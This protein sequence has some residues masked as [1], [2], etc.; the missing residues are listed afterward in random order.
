[1]NNG[2]ILVA[3]DRSSTSRHALQWAVTEGDRLEA[4]VEP[5]YVEGE[6]DVEALLPLSR[7]AALLVLGRLPEADV[8]GSSPMSRCLRQASCPVAVVP[9]VPVPEQTGAVTGGPQGWLDGLAE[10]PVR[11]VMSTDVLGADSATDVDTAWRMMLGAGFAHLPVM[12]QGRCVGVVHEADLLWRMYGWSQR[13]RAPLVADV[14]RKPAPTVAKD[15]TVREAAEALRGSVGDAVVVTDEEE[16]VGMLTA[17]DLHAALLRQPVPSEGPLVVGV[18][19]SAGS[20]YAL[21]WG[22][23]YAGQTGRGVLASSVSLLAPRPAFRT[24]PAPRE[25]LAS[26]AGAHKE[27]L[28]TALGQA[29]PSET[30]V[31]SAVVYGR[32][33]PTLCAL[34]A[35]AAGLVIGSHGAGAS[36]DSLLGSASAYCVRNARCP[37]IVIPPALTSGSSAK[38][39][40]G[41][42]ARDG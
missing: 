7:D 12:E 10:R 13:G 26:A 11:E 41:S 9:D 37:V 29:E 42:A 21:T 32:P 38:R 24:L 28:D 14:A 19:G 17:H 27:V 30:P 18:D 33:G 5:I 31:R 8:L 23:R 36:P 40:A 1:M 35:H 39:V 34:A 4:A 3:L 25:E 20:Q 16:V 2:R 15:L 6:T 22:L